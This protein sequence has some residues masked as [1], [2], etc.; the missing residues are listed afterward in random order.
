MTNYPRTSWL[1][2][3]QQFISL[4]F[5]NSVSSLEGQ[6]SAPSGMVKVARRGLGPYS[7]DGLGHGASISVLPASLKSNWGFHRNL[8]WCFMRVSHVQLELPHNEA[9][10]FKEEGR[11]SGQPLKGK[12][13]IQHNDAAAMFYVSSSSL[14]S[15]SRDSR[16]DSLF[17]SRCNTRRYLKLSWNNS[18][19]QQQPLD[20]LR[21][22]QKTF[23]RHKVK[24]CSREMTLCLGFK[25]LWQE[26]KM[27]RIKQ[28]ILMV[29][30][31]RWKYEGIIELYF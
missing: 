15:Q 22:C 11:G 3:H 1:K 8:Q 29:F 12:A 31:H 23:Q 25:I 17:P 20:Y 24:V 26:R 21:K 19:V 16:R 18:Q 28:G 4:Q 7:P 30:A 14:S 27:R 10:A 9:A 2:K 13:W 6:L 5:C